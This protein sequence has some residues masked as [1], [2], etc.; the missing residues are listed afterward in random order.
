MFNFFISNFDLGKKC[1]LNNGAQ[2]TEGNFITQKVSDDS[3]R[4]N[5]Q[6]EEIISCQRSGPEV[7]LQCTGCVA[8]TGEHIA[9]ASYNKI[10]GQWTQCRRTIDGCRMVNVTDECK[11]IQFRIFS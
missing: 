7:E 1:Q 11:L 8:V 4:T 6:A 3:L 5:L 9:V 10:N 2:L